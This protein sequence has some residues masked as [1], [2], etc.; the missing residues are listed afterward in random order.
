MAI[1]YGLIDE[2]RLTSPIFYPRPEW[3]PTPP[4]AT[5]HFLEVEPWKYRLAQF[6]APRLFGA[7]G[8]Q[9]RVLEDH[10]HAID[11]DANLIGWHTGAGSAGVR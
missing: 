9:G 2:L 3:S 6:R 10:E 7:S 4:G 8:I 1:E 11:S 5:D